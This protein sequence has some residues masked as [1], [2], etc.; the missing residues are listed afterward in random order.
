VVWWLAV[1]IGI[2]VA[3]YAPTPLDEEWTRRT[4][5]LAADNTA[6]AIDGFMSLTQG[7]AA[8]EE[9]IAALAQ[10]C[11]EPIRGELRRV[12]IHLG[13]GSS[14]AAAADDARARIDS[15]DFD[16]FAAALQTQTDEIGGTRTVYT[17]LRDMI[18]RRR[19]LRHRA[20]RVR[21][22]SFQI[23][24]GAA[25]AGFILLMALSLLTP[26]VTDSFLEN[27]V[28]RIA[29]AIGLCGL[30][31]GVVIVRGVIARRVGP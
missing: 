5:R 4:K 17:A 26:A 19:E 10:Q 18:G 22:R 24:A 13:Q 15:P 1:L 29:F 30:A 21:A 27:R 8:P 31:A 25:G 28:G 9:A 11:D 7:G 3:L 14:L 12:Q 6:D 2:A 20:S 23:C 16:L